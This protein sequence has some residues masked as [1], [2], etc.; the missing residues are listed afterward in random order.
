MALQIK[1]GVRLNG[2]HSSA[3]RI[4]Y[5]ASIIYEEIG[6]PLVI[7]SALDGEH[8]SD[9]KHYVGKAIDIRKRHLT[10]REIR[11]V[12]TQLEYCLGTEYDVVNEKTHI[13]IEHD[14]D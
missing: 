12:I 8:R 14:P 2:L 13:H 11:E 6:K 1:D 7:T 10:D 5:W 4:I 9:S 3:I